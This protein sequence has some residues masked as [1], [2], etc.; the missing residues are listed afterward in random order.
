MTLVYKNEMSYQMVVKKFLLGDIHGARVDVEWY[1]LGKCVASNYAIIYY[2]NN[3]KSVMLCMNHVWMN[4][5]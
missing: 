5:Y 3:D 2:T 4:K 1:F